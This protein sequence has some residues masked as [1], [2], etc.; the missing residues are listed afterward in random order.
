MATMM[1]KMNLVRLI[2]VVTLASCAFALCSATAQTTIIYQDDFSGSGGPLNGTTPDVSATGA[3]WIAGNLFYDNGWSDS[4][5]ASSA[6]GQGA[7]LPLTV[8]NG[9]IYVAQAQMLNPNPN[10]I[11]FGFLSQYP[12]DEPTYTWDMTDWRTRHSNSG[13]AWVLVRNHPDQPD[14]QGFLGYRTGNQVINLTDP[15][16][17]NLS[18]WNTYTITLNTMNP[19]QWTAE[20]AINGVSYWSGNFTPGSPGIGGI[21]FSHERN[22]TANTGAWID[23]FILT[24]VPEPNSL[25][26]VGLGILFAALRFRRSN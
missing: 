14:I 1:R 4:V 7:W 11:A 25:A 2:K 13:Y 5:V 8:Y 12:N 26:L 3:S 16:G 20:I 17:I 6:N 15:P 18:D 23:N 24:E 21:G 9:R 19:A 22:A 10:W